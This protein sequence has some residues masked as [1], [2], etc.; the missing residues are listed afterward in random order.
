MCEEAADFERRS[1]ERI[2]DTLAVHPAFW[3]DYGTNVL[4]SRRTALI[5]DPAD[6]R[7]PT[8]TPAAQ[9]KSAARADA[10][11]RAEGPEDFSLGERCILFGAGPPILPGPY[12]NNMQIVQT[13]ETVVVFN[14]MI[15]DARIVPM[16][17]RPHLPPHIRPLLTV[18]NPGV[19]TSRWTAAFPMA[20]GE[21]VRPGEEIDSLW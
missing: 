10:R 1:A 15:H 17:G 21:E 12:N 3:L 19:F 16:D 6:G 2:R 11:R 5:V 8:L 9:Q 20:S 7:V 14:E 4:A 18:D 13:R